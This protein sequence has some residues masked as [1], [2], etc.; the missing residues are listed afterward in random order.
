MGVNYEE[1][2]CPCHWSI[3]VEGETKW[4]R[5]RDT[6]MAVN[7][8]VLTHRRKGKWEGRDPLR[9]LSKRAHVWNCPG[10]TRVTV[11]QGWAHAGTCS[12]VQACWNAASTTIS[13]PSYTSPQSCAREMSS[14]EF[15]LLPR[16]IY[17]MRWNKWICL[18]HS[19]LV[20][21]WHDSYMDAFW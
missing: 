11:P 10:M 13:I 21:R 7:G 14:G 12:Q 18:G 8:F 1:M 5:V 3:D 4:D 2:G 9:N 20:D 16:A 19:V 15:V 6:K 17:M